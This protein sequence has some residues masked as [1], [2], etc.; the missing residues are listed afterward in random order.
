MFQVDAEKYAK[1]FDLAGS[2]QREALSISDAVSAAEEKK[3]YKFVI[4]QL[5]RFNKS[6]RSILQV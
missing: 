2:A 3:V 1:Y 5:N 6:K 4:Y